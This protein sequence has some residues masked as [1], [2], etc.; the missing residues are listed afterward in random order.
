MLSARNLSLSYGAH[1]V[2][3]EVDFHLK[4]GAVTALLGANGTGKSTFL[5]ALAGL[6]P[7]RGVIEHL[8]LGPLSRKALT[9]QVV[10]L[11]QDTGARSELTVMDVVLLGRLRDLKLRLPPGYLEEAQRC[12]ARFGLTALEARNLA[13]LSGGQR[14]LVYLAQALFRQPDILLL[15]EPTAALDLRHQ[16]LV[17]DQVQRLCREEG[18]TVVAALHDL[19][20]AA[21]VADHVVCLYDG[22]VLAEGSPEKVLTAP[23]LRRL[24]GVEVEL[25]RDS[26]GKL[27]VT[28]VSALASPSVAQEALP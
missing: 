10:Y 15:D 17:L 8:N 3:K 9:Q 25:N 24:Y 1:A 12:L 13:T 5:K 20:L 4:P 2:L 28:P 11:P 21:R 16:L 22:R 18:T 7:A 27:L 6:L 26:R 23:L 19:S 14:Q